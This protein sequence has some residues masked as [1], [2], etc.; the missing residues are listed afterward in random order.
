MIRYRREKSLRLHASADWFTKNIYSIAPC[1][2]N[3]SVDLF[4]AEIQRKTLHSDFEVELFSSK[5]FCNFR[6]LHSSFTNRFHFL[7]GGSAVY[8]IHSTEFGYFI[9]T[10]NQWIEVSS[11]TLISYLNLE[12]VCAF[13]PQL[14]TVDSKM[15]LGGSENFSSQWSHCTSYTK[16]TT[17]LILLGSLYKCGFIIYL[18]KRHKTFCSPLPSKFSKL[19]KNKC[20]SN[21]S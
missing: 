9:D 5:G 18:R 1:T 3:W 13:D 12:I 8:Y 17:K 7:H 6:L 14:A 19:A 15:A 20:L 10:P 4:A 16:K 11:L 21:L 2:V